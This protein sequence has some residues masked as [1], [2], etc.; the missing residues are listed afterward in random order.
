MKKDN[1]IGIIL[2]WVTLISPLISFYLTSI[3]GEVGIFG[4][5]G[6][7]RYSW[8]IWLFIPIVILSIIVGIKLKKDKQKYKKNLIVAFVCLPLIMIFGSY[9]F[10]FNNISYDPNKVVLVEQQIKIDLPKQIKIASQKMQTY[11][12]S[13]LKIINDE[14]KEKF[15]HE[16]DVN[17]L[18]QKQLSS[19][20]KSL[21]PFDVQYE[22]VKFD[23]FVFY[24]ITN[25]E[26]NQ[27]P[28]DGEYECIFMAYNYELQRLIIIDD[29]KIYLN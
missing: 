15:E 6:I 26:Y 7:I 14:T 18:W 23:S 8:I 21:L 27:Y 2:F 13:Y 11:N 10:I 22:I 12:L 16:L 17:Q 9:R 24:N 25:D 19:K 5:L 20:I 1:V 3:I 29:Y 4:I 28:L